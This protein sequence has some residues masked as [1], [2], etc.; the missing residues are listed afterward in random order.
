MTL[1]TRP[2]PRN[3][4][5]LR[6]L[7][8]KTGASERSIARWTSEPREVYLERANEKRTEILKLRLQGLS[9][10]AIAE[11]LGCSVGIVH[12]YVTEAKKA[13]KLPPEIANRG[14][15][16]PRKHPQ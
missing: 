8:E 10:K 15:G 3:G 7:A 12:K 9:I 13:G 4:W 11:E 6:Q 16:R 1:T 2:H 5:T 14:R